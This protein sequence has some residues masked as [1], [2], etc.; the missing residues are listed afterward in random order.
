MSASSTTSPTVS[1]ARVQLGTQLQ[2]RHQAFFHGVLAPSSS[3]PLNRTG[4]GLNGSR[5]LPLSSSAPPCR[6][7]PPTPVT[8]EAPC[9][10]ARR[11]RHSVHCDECAWMELVLEPTHT[12]HS[13]PLSRT[14]AHAVV[15]H[16][17][18]SPPRL[19]S[20]SWLNRACHVR[21][22]RRAYCGDGAAEFVAW[23][24]ARGA[25]L[26]QFFE[27]GQLQPQRGDGGAGV[28]LPSPPQHDVQ[29]LG[30]GRERME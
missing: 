22:R 18:L 29:S 3:S 20:A 17:T 13:L 30:R 15:P 21:F 16:P 6:A 25:P 12:S 27:L 23:L 4:V 9:R 28:A 8:P 7:S 10:P 24:R 1:A 19:D 11:L 2:P 14:Q 26:G 5:P